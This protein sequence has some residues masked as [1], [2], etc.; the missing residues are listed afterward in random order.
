MLWRVAAPWAGAEPGEADRVLARNKA[1][2]VGS[3]LKSPSA[4]AFTLAGMP[5][6]MACETP[7]PPRPAWSSH[8]MTEL[9]VLSGT[10]RHASPGENVLAEAVGIF[11]EWEAATV[12]PARHRPGV[13]RLKHTASGQRAQQQP[14][15]LGVDFVEQLLVGGTAFV[16]HR[17][18]Q[19][20]SLEDA[21]DDEV[22]EVFI[23]I[24]QRAKAG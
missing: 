22:V 19:S 12:R 6:I 10:L 7:S 20:V 1:A 2:A 5:Y 13:L 17:R 9:L 11:V 15:D 14:A 23:R 24:E 16:K 3:A 4:K 8:R 18:S 21:L